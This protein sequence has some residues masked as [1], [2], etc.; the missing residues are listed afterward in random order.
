LN[1]SKFNQCISTGV[2]WQLR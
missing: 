2:S 1:S